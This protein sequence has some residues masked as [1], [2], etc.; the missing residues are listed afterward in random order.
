MADHTSR[1]K[2]AQEMAS[3]SLSQ[4]HFGHY[5]AGTFN[6]NIV[7]MNATM[8]DIPLLMGYAPN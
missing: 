5:M 2:K 1:C 7:I 8:V 4:V 6:P 3:L